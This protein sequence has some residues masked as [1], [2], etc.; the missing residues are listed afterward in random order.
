ML[1]FS[2]HSI[3]TKWQNINVLKIGNSIEIDI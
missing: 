3:P 1:A 2:F